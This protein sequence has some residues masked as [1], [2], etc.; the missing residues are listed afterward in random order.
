MFGSAGAIPPLDPADDPWHG[1][2]TLG[3]APHSPRMSRH[4][5]GFDA[6]LFTDPGAFVSAFG[7][8]ILGLLVLTGGILVYTLIVNGF[9]QHLS[10]RVMFAKED[11]EGVER[12][13]IAGWLSY[14][15]LFPFVSFAFFLLLSIALLFLSE[16]GQSAL[17][18]YTLSM[19][20]VAAVRVAAYVSE[21]ASVDLAKLLPLGLL[22]VFLVRFE[23]TGLFAAF[24][25]LT[26]ALEN[27]DVLLAF[28]VVVL[29]LEYSLRFLRAIWI[30][31]AGDGGGE[32]DEGEEE[33]PAN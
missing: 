20:I 16:E 18:V 31:I 8:E 6:D 21:S 26:R 19:A 11:E 2:T 12:S 25:Q 17:E 4:E 33:V 1:R 15:T 7:D 24:D 10:Q 23:F 13:G 3:A 29:V 27:L 22:G 28:F 30:A 14:V 5:G 32:H 9:Y